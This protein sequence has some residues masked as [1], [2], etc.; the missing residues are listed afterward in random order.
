MKPADGSSDTGTKAPAEARSA[1]PVPA[2]PWRWLAAAVLLVAAWGIVAYFEPAAR[3]EAFLHRAGIVASTSWELARDLANYIAIALGA[4][5]AFGVIWLI[6]RSDVPS[7]RSSARDIPWG[8]GKIGP[9]RP[10]S[11]DRLGTLPFSRSLTEQ[12][13]SADPKDGLVFGLEGT[14]GSGKSTVVSFREDRL[15]E[16][17]RE[18]PNI[19]TVR[20]NPWWFSGEDDLRQQLLAELATQLWPGLASRVRRRLTRAWIA[21]RAFGRNAPIGAVQVGT[22]VAEASDSLVDDKKSAV[23]HFAALARDLERSELHVIVLIEDIDRLPAH[24]IRSVFTLAKALSEL[25]LVQ[26][27]VYDRSEVVGSFR[28]V[29]ADG[30]AYLQKLVTTPI[31]MPMIAESRLGRWLTVELNALVADV[32]DSRWDRTLWG[33]TVRPA[34]EHFIAYPRDVRRYVNAVIATYLPVKENVYAIDFLALTCLNVFAHPVVEAIKRER[35][36]LVND[37]GAQGIGI[38]DDVRRDRITRIIELAPEEDREAVRELIIALFREAARLLGTPWLS[39]SASEARALRRVGSPTH[40]EM[41][42]TRTLDELGVSR[43]EVENLLGSVAEDLSAAL[44]E[45]RELPTNPESQP[46]LLRALTDLRAAVRAGRGTDHPG[47]VLAGLMMCADQLFQA[48]EYRPLE[49]DAFDEATYLALD[50]LNGIPDDAA[51]AAAFREML[52]RGDALAF[53]V[54]LFELIRSDNRLA[55]ADSEGIS[56]MLSARLHELDPIELIRLPHTPQSLWAWK[57]LDNDAPV[58]ERVQ[59]VVESDEGFAEFASAMSY[60][61]YEND[62]VIWRTSPETIEAFGPPFE[63]AG[64]RAEALLQVN[65]DWLREDHRRGLEALVSQWRSPDTRPSG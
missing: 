32:D 62:R 28:S 65:P 33:G 40:S 45:L 53:A 64:P 46:K 16:A 38:G 8:T 61:G 50:L 34:I 18:N 54:R 42:F 22:A 36:L 7:R 49:N 25:P 30:E 19:R 2:R 20:F 60:I 3:A 24:E 17:S 43:E 31:P 56:A 26:L 41:Y 4:V 37:L 52:D 14:W 10:S 12:L 11:V 1:P 29:S 57:R 15:H 13:L 9:D 6:V 35:R 44:L 63:V 48:E 58:G 51:R 55:E 23:A 47:E 27:L 5:V 59:A 21:V 39:R